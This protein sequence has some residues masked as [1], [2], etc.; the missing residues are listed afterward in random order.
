MLVSNLRAVRKR[1]LGAGLE[2]DVCH[3]LLARLIFTQFLFQRTDSDGRPAISQ[4]PLDGRFENNLKVVYQHAK[5]LGEVLQ[6]KEET[7]ALFH[8]LNEKFNGDL[9]P[10]KGQ[11]PEERKAEWKAEKRKVTLDHLKILAQFVS[12]TIIETRAIG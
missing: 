8:W 12:G 4:S 2:R 3:A 10:G 1:L 6:S 11:T 7:Y 9:F 5:A